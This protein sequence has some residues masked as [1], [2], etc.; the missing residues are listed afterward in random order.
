MTR[1][2][3]LLESY[4]RLSVNLHSASWTIF[5]GAIIKKWHMFL[6]IFSYSIVQM[7]VISQSNNPN[8][9]ISSLWLCKRR[10]SCKYSHRTSLNH[11]NVHLNNQLVDKLH[12]PYV[13]RCMWQ[14]PKGLDYRKE[15]AVWG[16][17]GLMTQSSISELLE[18]SFQVAPNS[19]QHLCCSPLLS[20]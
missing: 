18:Q 13:S 16:K 7:L 8:S 17:P 5:P 14:K 15:P 2:I 20:F 4:F 11:Q 12:Q 9:K 1:W 19:S 3:S 6:N 10:K